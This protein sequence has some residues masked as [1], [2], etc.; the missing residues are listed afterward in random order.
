M[1]DIRGFIAGLF[2]LTQ[3]VIANPGFISFAAYFNPDGTMG[4]FWG[5]M[6]VMVLAVAIGFA[7]T[8]LLGKRTLAKKA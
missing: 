2:G 1:A 5:M 8:L 6:G 7:V 4:N 3:F